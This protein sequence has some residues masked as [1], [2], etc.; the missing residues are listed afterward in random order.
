MRFIG[1]FLIVGSAFFLFKDL[2]LSQ[3]DNIFFSS[4]TLLGLVTVVGS[5]TTARKRTMSI[6]QKRKS[7]RK[8]KAPALA[9]V[10]LSR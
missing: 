1:L 7:V 10:A 3:I 6:I 5:W 8:M 2:S 4:T 9:N